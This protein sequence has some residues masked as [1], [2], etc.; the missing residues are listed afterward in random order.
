MIIIYL[1]LKC[2]V[3]ASFIQTSD[4]VAVFLHAYIHTCTCQPSLV[5]LPSL[6]LISAV[7]FDTLI[8]LFSFFSYSVCNFTL[9]LFFLQTIVYIF[10]P[11]IEYMY[12]LLLGQKNLQAKP[13]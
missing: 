5:T 2:W 9:S 7:S 4:K 8:S 3:N 11:V 13:F 12:V 10:I 1:I 6:I